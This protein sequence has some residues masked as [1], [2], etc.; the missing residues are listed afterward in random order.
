VLLTAFYLLPVAALFG[1]VQLERL[2]RPVSIVLSSP[3]LAIFTGLAITINSYTFVTLLGACFL[4]VG[5]IRER[6]TAAPFFWLLSLIIVVQ[7]PV[8]AKY[9]FADVPPFTIVQLS[10]RFSILLLLVVAIAWQDEL[11]N[12]SIAPKHG[13]IP[14]ASVVV[15]VW[16]VCTVVLVGLQLADVH[17]HKHGPL[18]VSEAPEYATRWARP[19]YDWGDS[20]AT[21]FANDSQN[22]AWPEK[23]GASLISSIRKPYSDT[24]EYSARSSSIALMRRAYW[25]AWKATVD[26]RP[27]A[28]TPDSLGRLT[29]TVPEGKHRLILWLE[30]SHSAEIGA[31]IS[32]SSLLTLI[33][34]WIF[35]PKS[36]KSKS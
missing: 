33:G 7:L 10:Y 4:W 5:W 20:L 2:W 28:T 27:V 22:I 23:D 15:G 17:V 11:R 8:I 9:L 13:S 29:L 31:W 18:P 36:R 1:D 25:P 30:T 6:R 32:I 19:Y 26:G 35:I 14:I 34:I 12:H 21:P 16:S 3:F 24:I